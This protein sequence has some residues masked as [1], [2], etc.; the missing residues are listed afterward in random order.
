MLGAAS[1][2]AVLG[3]QSLVPDAAFSGSEAVCGS[4]KKGALRGVLRALRAPSPAL[5]LL[6]LNGVI[7][8]I[9]QTLHIEKLC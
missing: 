9:L 2:G 1:M 8:E 7:H 3:N 5:K 6:A 4:Q